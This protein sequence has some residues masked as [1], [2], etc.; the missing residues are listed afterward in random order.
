MDEE[1]EWMGRHLRRSGGYSRRRGSRGWAR[2]A[3]ATGREDSRRTS[4]WSRAPILVPED[5]E[6][7]NKI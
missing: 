6:P 5:L 4:T 3:N 2:L 7:E 1:M